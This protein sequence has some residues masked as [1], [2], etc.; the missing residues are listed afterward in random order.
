M[1]KRKKVFTLLWIIIALLG[2]ASLVSL[3]LF[4]HWKGIFIAGMGGFLIINLL[5]SMFFIRKNFKD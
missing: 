2:T 4:P 5:L 1:V 3:L